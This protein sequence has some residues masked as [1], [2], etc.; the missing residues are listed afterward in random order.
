MEGNGCFFVIDCSCDGV[1]GL[2]SLLVKYY[3]RVKDCSVFILR[4]FCIYCFKFFLKVGVR[5]VF[6][7]LVEFE[8]YEVRKEEKWIEVFF[9]V[10]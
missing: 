4:K 7:L 1:Y 6:Y 2:V 3:D 10:V 5:K 9:D 8:Y